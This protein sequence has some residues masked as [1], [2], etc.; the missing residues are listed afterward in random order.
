[1]L[2]PF[3]INRIKGVKFSSIPAQLRGVR[4]LSKLAANQWESPPESIMEEWLISH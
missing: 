1:M 3:W 2:G 4:D